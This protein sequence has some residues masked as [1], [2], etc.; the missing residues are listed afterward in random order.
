MITFNDEKE[1]LFIVSRIITHESLL[2]GNSL[3]F[4]DWSNF[5]TFSLVFG[6][7]YFFSTS[8]GDELYNIN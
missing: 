6:Y 8:M 2:I 3:F 1:A 5:Y 7:D 4:N